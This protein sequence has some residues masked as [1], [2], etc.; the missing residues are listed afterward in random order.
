MAFS[1]LKPILCEGAL[2]HRNT[3][4]LYSNNLRAVGPRHAQLKTKQNRKQDNKT[5]HRDQNKV[6]NQLKHPCPNTLVN[7]IKKQL[8]SMKNVVKMT[9]LSCYLQAIFISFSF[10]FHFILKYLYRYKFHI[11]IHVFQTDL[12]KNNIK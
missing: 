9:S 3:R 6:N 12:L 5:R 8:F 7:I 1:V 10:S 11:F 2:R 4:E